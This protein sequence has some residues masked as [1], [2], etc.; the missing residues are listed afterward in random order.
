[1]KLKFLSLVA[2]AGLFVASCG[3]TYQTTSD[4]AAYNV[5]VPMN[6]RGGFAAS[7]PDATNVAWNSYDITTVP[8]DWELTG[9]NTLDADDYTVSFDMRGNKYYAWY[10]ANGNLVG[11]AYA[12]SDYTN[13]PYAVNTLLQQ[14]YNTYTIDAVQREMWGSQTAYEIK[15]KGTDESKIKLLVDSDGNI[16]KEKL[17]D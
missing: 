3:T 4:N 16:I 12:I 2:A 6:I 10:D 9:W 8:I 13:L 15:L 1:M 7:Y 11:S 14:K 5:N 17:K